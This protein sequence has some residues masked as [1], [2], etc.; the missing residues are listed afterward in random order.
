MEP[1]LSASVLV[2]EGSF[3]HACSL[4]CRLLPLLGKH[5]EVFCLAHPDLIQPKLITLSNPGYLGARVILTEGQGVCRPAAWTAR[6]G[7]WRVIRRYVEE[8]LLV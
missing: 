2:K 8:L 1:P 4:S 3:M 7:K 6:L 5:A